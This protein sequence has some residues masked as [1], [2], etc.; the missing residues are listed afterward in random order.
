V[1]RIGSSS[2]EDAGRNNTQVGSDGRGSHGTLGLHLLF[3][4]LRKVNME[5]GRRKSA[6]NSDLFFSYFNGITK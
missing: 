5:S 6:H 4:K 1:E 2:D 3:W